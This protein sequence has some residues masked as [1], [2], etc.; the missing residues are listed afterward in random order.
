MKLNNIFINPNVNYYNCE[1]NTHTEDEYESGFG[2]MMHKLTG[3]EYGEKMIYIDE[4][5]CESG[6][7]DYGFGVNYSGG[8]I[9]GESY[10]YPIE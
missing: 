5:Y 2:G 8:D 4:S 9:H 7:F 6:V 3:R 1:I 10:A